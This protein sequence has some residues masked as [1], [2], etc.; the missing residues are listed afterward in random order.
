M[1]RGRCVALP[2]L[3]TIDAHA[4]LAATDSRF[5]SKET[6]MKRKI[7]EAQ[8]WTVRQLPWWRWEECSTQKSREQL[9]N[10]I[11]PF[12]LRRPEPKR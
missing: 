1:V 10:L 2:A 12:D 4:W 11:V 5:L 3:G 7:V 6:V 8:G 9:L